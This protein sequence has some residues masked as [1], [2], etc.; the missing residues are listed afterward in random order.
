M[1]R[2]A[3]A[4]QYSCSR[5]G[6]YSYAGVKVVAAMGTEMVESDISNSHS[7][8]MNKKNAAEATPRIFVKFCR[9]DH[10]PLFYSF[11]VKMVLTH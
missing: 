11:R 8:L 4:T 9:L 10:R 5:W 3:G 7:K 6:V 2:N 1:R